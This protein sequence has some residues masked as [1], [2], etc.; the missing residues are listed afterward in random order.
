MRRFLHNGVRALSGLLPVN[1]HSLR[2]MEDRLNMKL[3][4]IK[5]AVAK[6]AAQSKEAF[7]EISKRL[8]DLQKQIDDLIAGQSDPEVTDEQFAKDLADLQADVKS[9][10]DIVPNPE[11]PPGDSGTGAGPVSETNPPGVTTPVRNT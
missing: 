11:N 3:S 1:L 9:L 6:A 4:E 10:A 7:G 2:K 8:T 5:A